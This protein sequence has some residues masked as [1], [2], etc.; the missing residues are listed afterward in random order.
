MADLLTHNI[1]QDTV[2]PQRLVVMLHGIGQH[3]G[4]MEEAARQLMQRMPGTAVVIPDA[5]L[6]MHYTAEKVARVREK[7][8][9]GFDGDKAR[10]WFKTDMS[11]WP[12]MSLR[13]AFN[14]LPVVH[15]VNQLADHYRDAFGLRGSDIAFFGLSQG[16]AIA[17]YASMARDEES[18]SKAAD[19]LAAAFAGRGK[20][21][22]ISSGARPFAAVSTI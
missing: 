10:S 3:H 12:V 16:G 4:Y 6:K 17:L 20:D 2:Q 9:P 19:F 22:R 11:G 21:N 15:K 14:S 18:I 1:L 8:D 5:P 7:Y 13:L